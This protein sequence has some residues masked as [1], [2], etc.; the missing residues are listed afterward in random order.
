[1]SLFFA[2]KKKKSPEP[3][4]L[5]QTTT[6]S[7]L[8]GGYAI[9][10][11]LINNANESKDIIINPGE[12]NKNGLSLK[13]L[14]DNLILA[15][16]VNFIRL[17][18]NNPNLSMISEDYHSLKKSLCDYVT[19]HFQT[20]CAL[21]LPLSGREFAALQEEKNQ[22]QET[23][24]ENFNLLKGVITEGQID[25]LLQELYAT[26]PT[27]TKVEVV[28]IIP[29][30]L[31]A[32]LWSKLVP[33]LHSLHETYKD[34][35]QKST[36]HIE[37]IKTS[38]HE[39]YVEKSTRILQFEQIIYQANARSEDLCHFCRMFFG[40]Q[41]AQQIFPEINQK[42]EDSLKIEIE[43]YSQKHQKK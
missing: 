15:L 10:N 31:D 30:P 1:M 28:P 35:I 5:K 29:A 41:F 4:M 7:A 36:A 17:T 22:R 42:Y 26:H 13:E 24:K 14:Q 20:T 25:L 34:V 39:N 9:I 37:K 40:S 27:S 32:T 3:V 38:P 12:L 8:M 33:V 23:I 18:A 21:T 19:Q 11:H 16:I 2:P 43:R 6:A